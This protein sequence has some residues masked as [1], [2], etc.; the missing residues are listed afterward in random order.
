MNHDFDGIYQGAKVFL[1]GHTG[2]KGSWLSLWLRSLGAEVVGYSLPP[3]TQPNNFTVSRVEECLSQHHIGDIRDYAKLKEAMQQCAPDIVFHLAAQPIVL[4]SFENPLETFEINGNG[5]ANVLEAA[6]DCPTIKAMVMVTS[7]KCY[8]N[9]EWIWGYRENDALGGHDPYSASKAISEL[10]ISSYQASFFSKKS[11]A[12]AVASVRA[13]NVIGGGDFSDKRIVP[14]CMKAL[15]DR[16]PIEVR[17]P[18]SVRPWLNVLDP[19]RG[20]LLLGAQLLKNGHEFAEAW[21][22][23]PLE[24]EAV[25]VEALVEKAVTLWGEGDWVNTSSPNAKPE[26]GMLRL[27]WDKAANRLKWKPLYDWTAAVEETVDWFKAFDR[28]RRQ[29]SED[30]QAICLEHIHRYLRSVSLEMEETAL[31]R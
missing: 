21:N 22:F 26:M 24:Q 28:Y 19:L 7:D 11:D 15:M 25:T 17:N 31:K 10:I 9:V 14:D 12:P 8:Q 2:F 3:P 4:H 6:R 5:T 27:N 29:Q 20:Y 23:G 13:G 18:R 16:V 30:M 1:T